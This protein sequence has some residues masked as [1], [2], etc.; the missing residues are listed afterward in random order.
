MTRETAIE[1]ASALVERF[2]AGRGAAPIIVAIDGGGGAG[3]STLADGIRDTIEDVAIIR[4][5]DFYRRLRDFHASSF[6]AREAYETYFDW[7]R[8]RDDAL[9]PL[10]SGKPARYQRYD[11][12]SDRLAEWIETAPRE[13]VVVEGVYS[14]R[15]EL[16]AMLDA[17]IFV[18]T[19]RERRL[20]RMLARGHNAGNWIEP[21]M[22]AEDWY[23]ANVRPKEYADL[24]VP[25]T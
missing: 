18:E 6:D 7:R 11:W 9:V 15:P 8:L 14:M 25:G 21:W 5:D 19:P 10:R 22:A 16:R 3:K 1:A 4:C 12:S 13:V 2:R 17:G 23:F 20:R 24:V